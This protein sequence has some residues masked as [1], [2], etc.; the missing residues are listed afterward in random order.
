MRGKESQYGMAQEMS[1][2][3]INYEMLYSNAKSLIKHGL[4]KH[5]KTKSRIT[6]Q[7]R[8]SLLSEPASFI[9]QSPMA[10]V[11]KLGENTTGVNLKKLKIKLKKKQKQQ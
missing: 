4:P 8:L 11:N 6:D 7:S 5:L 9:S 3:E 10:V 2:T 1:I